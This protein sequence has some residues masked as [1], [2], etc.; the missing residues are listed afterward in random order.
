M[1]PLIS[2]V[3]IALCAV[4]LCA[5]IQSPSEFLGYALGDQFTYHH[6]VVAYYQHVAQQSP[7][8]RLFPYGKTNEGRDLLIAV[9][10]SEQ[11]L[12]RLEEIRRNQQ[13][14]AGYVQGD[15]K[16]AELPIVWLSYNIHGN[17]S[18]STEAAMKTL[19]T[20]ITADTARWLDQM[21]VILDPCIN[22]DGRDRYTNWYR[23][24][25]ASQM[26]PDPVAW[27]H[28]EPWPGGRFNHYL[29]DLNRDWCWQTQVETQLRVALYQSWLPHV[30]VDF[31][32]MGYNSTYYFAPAAKPYHPA[33]TPW[34]REFQQLAGK[35]QASHFDKNGWL[36]FTRETYDL[37]Y[38][39][40]GD[41]WPIF[42]GAIGFTFEQGGSGRAGRGIRTANG[43]TLTLSDRIAHHYTSGISTIETAFRN[44][45]R[46]QKEFNTFYTNALKNPYGSYRSYVIKGKQ[47]P[48]RTAA[49]LKLLDN[50]RIQYGLAAQPGRSY[51]GYSYQEVKQTSFRLEESDIVIS[52]FQPQSTLLQI[53]FEP[54]TVPEDSLTYDLTAWG[55]PYAYGLQTYASTENIGVGKR[56]AGQPAQTVLVPKGNIY[57][58]LSEWKDVQDVQF[59]AALLKA[60]IQS[61]FAAAPFESNGKTYARGTLIVTRADN[62]QDGFDEKVARIASECGQPVEPVFTGLVTEGSDFGSSSLGLVRPLR[63][64]IVNGQGV[65]ATT[66]G[67]VWHFFEQELRYPVTVLPLANLDQVDLSAFDVLILTD[68][69]YARVKTQVYEFAQQGGKVIAI[70]GALSLFTGAAP[71]GMPRTQVAATVEKKE[72]EAAKMSEKERPN[73]PAT[74]ALLRFSDRERNQISETTAGSI[75]KVLLDDTHPL[76]FGEDSVF[77][78]MKQSSEVLPMLN[79]PKAW[80]VG[81][82]KDAAPV[83]GFTGK[84]LQARMAGSLALG[85]ERYGSGTLVYFTDTPGFRGFWHSGKL[86]LGN[87]VF[88]NWD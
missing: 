51:N 42:Q 18:V 47:D 22:P 54:N 59:L 16:G 58:W 85:T 12:A 80:N 25:A 36:Y 43:D 34:Q 15:I 30:H 66:F 52:A 63:V 61:R 76:A 60:G 32:E 75:Y 8:I 44:K 46:L 74:P 64:A 4:K 41:T 24:A 17:E 2:F 83:S 19:H 6:K 27:E 88:L 45:E 86:L 29:F 21:I 10:G 7:R 82:V 35:N 38:P 84:K 23:Q 39:S 73:A 79:S 49:L 81:M 70:E 67:E 40:Y 11:N 37:L 68:G 28:Q 69:R 48:A 62:P 72:A 55:L 9:L 33:I 26:N 57:A 77:F 71:E 31:H 3:L 78:M 1:R 50:N 13:I 20:L 5:Q 14:R 87:A 53:L 56:P 65:S